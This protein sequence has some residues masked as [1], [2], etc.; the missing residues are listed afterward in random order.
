MSERIFIGVAWPYPNGHLHIG[1]IAGTFLPA[2]IFARYHRLA[3]NDVLM[4]SGS[5]CHGTPITVLAEQ[6]GVEP[7]AIADRYHASIVD[8]L[9]KLGV[10][11]DLYTATMTENHRLTVQEFFRR[12]L[13]QDQIYT[14]TMTLPYCENDKRFL[15]DRYVNG[16]CPHCGFADARGD[17]CDNC[18]RPLD[19]FDL[20]EPRCKFCGS[21]PVPRESEHF[22]LRLSAFADQLQAWV[23]Q[24]HQWRPNTYNF[25]VRYLEEGLHDRAITRD[26]EWGIPIPVPG[27]EDKRI[28]IWFENIIG[29]LSASK[30]WAQRSGDPERWRDFWEGNKAPSY[31]FIGKDN[32]FFHTLQWPA[33]LMGVGG[34]NFP[35]DVPTSEFL[36]LEGRSFSTSRGWAVW[37]PDYLSRFEPDPLRYYLSA[38]MPETAD[39]DFSWDDFVR[40]NNDELVA[41][42]G[43]LAHR[44]LTFTYRNFDKAVPDYGTFGPEEEAL[45]AL[46]DST[47]AA[48]GRSLSLC[49]FREAL[50][51][52]MELAHE[53]N[54]YLDSK[55]PWRTIRTDREAT[56]ITLGAGLSAVN[57][58]KVALAP[59][60]PFSSERLQTLL[61]F[62]KALGAGDWRFERIPP[63]QRLPEPKP[64]FSKFDDKTAE[65][66][67]QRLVQLASR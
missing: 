48:V 60:L 56:A 20:I 37:V 49:R 46:C 27:Y 42:Y 29:Y 23:K 52:A 61:G 18:G 26:L 62:S 31:Y 25:T 45:M 21:G 33:E 10:S 34:L 13:A 67:R 12:L 51:T 55:A 32:L 11:F 19:P 15:P 28:Y 7:R 35:Y 16:T 9:A 64:L 58:L 3:G 36:T 17:E 8:S 22:F 50:R 54:R 1:H 65:E 53:S 38:I 5:D 57:A 63:L 4:V 59:F 24:Q 41:T 6:E 14:A 47:L 30:E 39:T 44:L 2:D 66:E 40:R 43:N